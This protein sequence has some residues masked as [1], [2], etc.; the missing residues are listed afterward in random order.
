MRAFAIVTAGAAALAVSGACQACRVSLPPA[1]R[2]ALGYERGAIS[3]IALVRIKQ[4]GYTQAPFS[5][6]HP[7]RA[8]GTVERVLRGS[9][10]HAVV[11][12][13]RGFGSSACDDGRLP[14]KAGERWVIYFWKRG[15]G[16]QPVWLSYPATLAYAADP[17]LSGTRRP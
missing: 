9:Y 8:S 12:F 3:A 14:P 5:D 10:P 16:D 6:A 17:F 2:L 15:A 1:R 4:A 13:E 11:S 7:W